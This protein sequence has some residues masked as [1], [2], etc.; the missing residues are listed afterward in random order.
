MLISLASWQMAVFHHYLSAS[1]QQFNN[2]TNY[3]YWETK[4]E[5]DTTAAI[6]S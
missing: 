5:T 4:L 1:G 2:P 6:Y 3:E